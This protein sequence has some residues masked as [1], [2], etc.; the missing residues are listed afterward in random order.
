MIA[1]SIASAGVLSSS[2]MSGENAKPSAPVMTDRM[3]KKLVLVPTT[4]FAS[5]IRRAPR[6]CP[7]RMTDAIE[8]PKLRL[9]RKNIRKFALDVAARA[10]SPSRRP[11]QIALMEPFNVCSTLPSRIGSEKTNSV[12]AIGPSVRCAPAEADAFGWDVAMMGPVSCSVGLKTLSA[13]YTRRR[14]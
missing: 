8:M 12:L 11:T 5:S 2:R 1:M 10:V 14:T 6:F 7:S 13:L 4:F 3:K 9:I